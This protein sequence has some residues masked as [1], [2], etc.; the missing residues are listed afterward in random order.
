MNTKDTLRT[1]GRNN[2][3]DESKVLR[4]F[5]CKSCIR[6]LA[7]CLNYWRN[8]KHETGMKITM[9]ASYLKI[10]ASQEHL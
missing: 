6:K 4:I 8:R 2:A 3:L 1:L 10:R 9:Y 7:K 5:N